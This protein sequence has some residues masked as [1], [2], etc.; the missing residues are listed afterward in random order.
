[1]AARHPLV[2]PKTNADSTGKSS[3]SDVTSTNAA[4]SRSRQPASGGRTVGAIGPISR[5]RITLV[6]PWSHHRRRLRETRQVFRIVFRCDVSRDPLV[7]DV[8]RSREVVP[9]YAGYVDS[10]ATRAVD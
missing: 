3:C 9:E 10:S 4:R 7:L 2:S 5:L 1:M 8:R 6:Y